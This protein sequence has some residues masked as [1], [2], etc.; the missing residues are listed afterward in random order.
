MADKNKFLEIV[1]N[2][3]KPNEK[4]QI[5]KF[6]EAVKNYKKPNENKQ[7]NK[8]LEVVKNYKKP[9]ENIEQKKQIN[10]IRY[11][12]TIKG[13]R[14]E[15]IK[16]E[17]PERKEIKTFDYNIKSK[18]I[19]NF[20]TQKTANEQSIFRYYNR[21]SE[22]AYKPLTIKQSNNLINSEIKDN[23]KKLDIENKDNKLFGTG[24]EIRFS[25]YNRITNFDYMYISV[26]LKI[27]FD[28]VFTYA[29]GRGDYYYKEKP[30]YISARL[31][32]LPDRIRNQD[33]EK[34]I[35]KAVK[36]A[37]APFGYEV[38]FKLVSWKFCYFTEYYKGERYL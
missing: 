22:K 7:I 23:K 27:Y 17:T 14:K 13:E 21:K 6:L 5:N 9:N 8:F 36:R 35:K 32:K 10:F 29:T 30:E 28:G 15:F 2:Y 31:K 11:Y 25:K 24:S 34:E 26:K 12:K 37:L 3:K 1:K 38:K 16:L 33:I 19:K 4:K 20:K 18:Q